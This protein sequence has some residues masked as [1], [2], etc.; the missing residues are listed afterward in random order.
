MDQVCFTTPGR[1]YLTN[2]VKY[3]LIQ[4]YELLET[5]RHKFYDKLVLPETY[6]YLF[7]WWSRYVS[8]FK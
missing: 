4:L 2:V 1:N 3:K 5:A 7:L 6:H 8:E